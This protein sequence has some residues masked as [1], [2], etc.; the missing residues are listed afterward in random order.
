MDPSVLED[1]GLNRLIVFPYSRHVGTR[2]THSSEGLEAHDDGVDRR[3]CVSGYRPYLSTK[4]SSS[5]FILIVLTNLMDPAHFV[6][7][8][9]QSSTPDNHD[10]G[11]RPPFR[12]FVRVILSAPD[13]QNTTSGWNML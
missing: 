3:S 6:L 7:D 8:I 12:W 9:H 11:R 13:V 2:K 1:V 10:L 4:K 5:T